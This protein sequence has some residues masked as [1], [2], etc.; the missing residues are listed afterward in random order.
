M[1][2]GLNLGN[3]RKDLFRASSL[4]WY[5]QRSMATGNFILQLLQAVLPV[6]SLY[7]IKLLV[8]ALSGKPGTE[9][10]AIVYIIIA[11]CAV[12]L[13][14]A[15]ASQLSTHLSTLQQQKI[16]D[17]VAALVLQK[18]TNVEY[19]YYENPEYHDSLHMAQMQSQF[20]IPQLVA[21]MNSLLQNGF[22]LIFLA[23][24][25]FSVQWWYALLFVSLS[26]PL[27]GIRWYFGHELYRKEKSYITL[28]REAG[29]YHHMLTAVSYAKEVRAFGFAA[30]FIDKFRQIREL[31]YHGKKTIHNRLTFY[32]IL[33]QLAEI[34]VMIYIFTMLAKD[35]WSGMLT[36]GSFVIYLQG[37]QRL[38]AGSRNFLQS[39]VQVF[40]QRLFLSD[41]F[42]FLDIEHPSDTSGAKFPDIN[43][44]LYVKNVSFTYPGTTRAVLKNVSIECPAGKIVAIVGE[45]GSGKSTLVK[46]I[47]NMYTLQS[48]QILIGNV[49]L[50]DI[51]HSSFR[52]GSYFLFQDFEKY[53]LSISE[54]I[55][56][57]DSKN[58]DKNRVIQ[59]AALAEAEE[60][61]S[62][63]SNGY[64]TRLGRAFENSEQ[65]SGGQWQKLGI[66]RM[67]YKN[68]PLV[69]LDE[70]TGSIDAIAEH[71]IFRNLNAFA[72]GKIVILI[73]HTLYNLKEADHI[74]VMKD[75]AIEE[76]GDFDTLISR[77]GTFRKMFDNQRL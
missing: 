75:G 53:Y 57:A 26:V 71:K 59:A 56:L 1:K 10:G 60:F 43:S 34:V 32:S 24:F 29:Y 36:L 16:N 67:F 30:E 3:F 11:I 15:V 50:R 27:A 7:L 55:T 12:Q 38:Q 8:E 9:F 37:F 13:F 64:D 69:V 49:P 2:K 65:L 54:N 17:H 41:L 31:V 74:Y 73:S 70:P 48:G 61:I 4:I 21:H 51:S 46:L 68:A 35:T 23:G 6:A 42:T 45:N 28:E 62:Q 47:A 20:R 63:L 5:A 14:T 25:L 77:N 44:G 52:S 18:A 19:T 66:A 39:L 72:A 22:S 33:I 76:E 40:Q 58:N